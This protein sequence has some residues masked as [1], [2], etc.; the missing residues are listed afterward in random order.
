[1]RILNRLVS[2]ISVLAVSCCL[3]IEV[4]GQEPLVIAWQAPVCTTP[5]ANCDSTDLG[6][7]NNFVNYELSSLSG[8]GV[9][10]PW[11]Q[12]DECTAGG[13][14]GGQ[15]AICT[16]SN[17]D[18]QCTSGTNYTNYYWCEVDQALLNYIGL[19]SQF[20]NKKIV[21]I[22]EPVNDQMT[23]NKNFTPPYVFSL[24]WASTQNSNPQDVVVCYGWPGDVGPNSCPVKG[25]INKG[26]YAIWNANGTL[27]VGCVT[28]NQTD[29]TC[30][31][32]SS[33]R[34]G[35]VSD[36]SGFPVLYEKP[37][38]AAYQQF[39]T[40]LAYH[41]SPLTGSANGKKI[42]PYI[43]YVR[44][45][46]ANGGEN[47]PACVNLDYITQSAWASKTYYPA[48]YI[49]N[50]AGV[51][52]IASGSG[53]SSSQSGATLPNC[54]PFG[55]TTSPDGTIPGWYNAG[56]YPMA[57]TT[58]IWPGPNGQFGL[59]AQPGGYWDNGYLTIW[60]PPPVS[61]GAPG[62]VATM[63]A[64]L[65]GL[66][67]SFPFD[68]SSHTGPPGNNNTGYADSEAIIASA[69]GLGF[70]MQSVNVGD[71]QSYA[72]QNTAQ[73][74][75]PTTR[76]DWAHNFHVYP[77]PVHHLQTE[78][79]G[80]PSNAD[81]YQI[82]SIAVD[83]TGNAT[84]MCASDCSMMGSPIYIS[85][86]STAAFN[87]IWNANCI[88]G[89]GGACMA[90]MLQFQVTGV[91]PCGPCGTGGDVFA[92]DYWPITI[93]F[94]IQHGVTSIEV[95][96]CSLDYAFGAYPGGFPT[97]TWVPYGDG[98]GCAEWSVNAATDA[99]YKNSLSDA[100]VG[101]PAGTG[102]RAGKTI[103]INGSQ[104]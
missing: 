11:A 89:S 24:N 102:V 14:P 32:A 104:Y 30:E 79:P 7:F 62:Y 16:I 36:F 15:S 56:S 68:I 100:Q 19:G 37:F 48:G 63:T 53:T 51:Q 69:N 97:T 92:P 57:N 54:A 10:V 43:A 3:S 85:G 4:R 61:T 86:Y 98:N 76:E 28:N 22:V 60:P 59:N 44:V 46:L 74:N 45:G 73:Y 12:V 40:A 82:A 95:W 64:F 18:S 52:Y 99:G 26:D 78:A 47:L 84:L 9:S 55:C 87:G 67:A 21:I 71:P 91:G 90:N 50:S 2:S 77:A 6:Y 41:Y 75:F 70:G 81:E 58:P 35:V 20:A 66:G 31:P 29:L 96:E 1:M 80:S 49:V 25:T 33:C 17:D 34:G 88:Q 13:L 93:P 38:T 5:L 27:N 42:A 65:K 103:L 94:A 72:A 39:L 23:N 8:I 83:G 101:Q